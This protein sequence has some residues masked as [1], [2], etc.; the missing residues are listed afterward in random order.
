MIEMAMGDE[1]VGNV[2][3]LDADL[4][5]HFARRMPAAHTV[6]IGQHLAM[7]FV[8]VSDI[9]HRKLAL[10]LDD[11][12]AIRQ[13]ARS[14]VVHAVDQAALRIIGNGGEFHDPQ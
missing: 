2:L 8:V 11:D 10:A 6:R 13:L 3:G 7:R 9:H 4:A 12:V 5:Q 1:D 14:L